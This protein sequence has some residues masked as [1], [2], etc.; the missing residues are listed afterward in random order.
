MTTATD[1]ITGALRNIGVYEAGEPLAS[2]D[3]NDALVVLNALL[4]SWSADH[5]MIYASVETLQTFTAGTYQYTVGNYVGGTFTGTLVSG[6]AV[7][8]GVTV[9]SNLTA[10]GD[11]TCDTV[12]ALPAGVTVLSF[13]AGAGTVTL[14]ANALQTIA[15]PIVFTYTIPGQFK[16]D[17]PLRVTNAFTRI[18]TSGSQLDYPMQ[19]CTAE[20][21]YTAIGFKGVAGPWPIAL[22]YQPTYPLGNMFF[23]PNPSQAAQLHLWTDNIFSQFASLTQDIGFPQGY[24][25][26]LI[27]NLA[28]ELAP[29]YGKSVPALLVKQAREAKVL[30]QQLNA[31]P[32]A[33]AAYDADIVRSQRNDAGWIM[34]GGFLP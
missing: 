16:M 1:L 29:E 34:H 17:R 11:V 10:N 15:T 8:S 7:I 13:N 4:D 9:P 28:L 31:D 2:D 3:A 18:T 33:V 23:Y 25:R 27:K 12:G 26:A 30:L 19:V 32:Q 22:F 6:S 14:S 5:L 20:D 24:V 21:Q